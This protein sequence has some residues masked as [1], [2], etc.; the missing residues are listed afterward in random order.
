MLQR[1]EPPFDLPTDTLLLIEQRFWESIRVGSFVEHFADD[2]AL[3][4]APDKHPALYSD[5]G[6]THVRDIAHTAA[7]LAARNDGVLVPARPPDRARFLRQMTVAMTYLHDIGMAAPTAEARRVHPQFAAQVALGTE[8]DDIIEGLWHHDAA[9]RERCGSV[10]AAI[11]APVD[12]RLLLR[13][14]LAMS[15]CH[16]KTA[17]PAPVLGDRALLRRFLQAGALMPLESQTEPLRSLATRPLPPSP[18]GAAA[19]RYADA[20]ADSFR[21]LVEPVPVAV[22]FADDIIDA[23]RLVRAADA[24]RRRGISLHTSGGFEI[25]ANPLTGEAVYGLRSRDGVHGAIVAVDNPI[26]AAES[27]IAYS[28]LQPD[29]ALRIGFNR[30]FDVPSVRARIVEMSAHLV[31]DIEADA[32]ESFVWSGAPPDV[33]LVGV[34][35]DPAFSA[36]IADLAM[37]RTARLAGRVVTVPPSI[38]DI[39]TPELDWLVGASPLQPDSALFE[40]VFRQVGRHGLDTDR[41]D[42][43]RAAAGLRVVRVPAGTE[44]L[45]V[46]T[47]SP[48]VVIPVEPGLWVH[49]AVA[50]EPHPL[51]PWLPVGAT[52]VIRGGARNAAVFAESAV[53]VVVIEADT[54]LQE[55]FRPYPVAQIPEIVRRWNSDPSRLEPT[56]ADSRR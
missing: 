46:G 34:P 37:R 35:G 8:C 11:G 47:G 38:D 36:E 25:C 20:V 28:T 17:V 2:P 55:W 21:W 48:I 4:A 45:Q 22:E 29:G 16:S 10:C 18:R 9:I 26:S 3:H 30:S 5:H 33:E 43:A 23:V 49:P 54:F 40:Q 50:S 53:T 51:H 1:G 15:L 13:E 6:V 12:G 32:V 7:E 27:N 56:R 19:E 39:A 42:P 31:A 44:L 52:G 24:L 14:V 41:I